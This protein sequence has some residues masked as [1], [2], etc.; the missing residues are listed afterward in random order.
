MV[1]T[2]EVAVT[3]VSGTGRLRTAETLLNRGVLMLCLF[4][5]Q[6]PALSQEVSGLLRFSDVL[7]MAESANPDLLTAVSGESVAE[8]HLRRARTIARPEL[9][10]TAE[11][12]RNSLEPSR[13]SEAEWISS[14]SQ[15]IETGG[16][17]RHRTRVAEAGLEVT[18]AGIKQAKRTLH[19]AVG[20]AFFTLMYR[21]AD[22]R[23]LGRLH[24][25]LE[26]TAALVAQSVDLGETAEN[27]HLLLELEKARLMDDILKL[28]QQRNNARIRLLALM[29]AEDI[30]QHITASD[31]LRAATLVDKQGA[32]IITDTGV[33]WS[34]S[35]LE[36]IAM[37]NHPDVLEAVHSLEQAQ[38]A[39]ALQRAMLIPNL[40]LNTGVRTFGGRV[41]L[42]AGIGLALPLWGGLDRGGLAITRS[43]EAQATAA[44][45][46]ARERVRAELATAVATVNHA[47]ER[48]RR[49][50]TEVLPLAY[51]LQV[52]NRT[53]YTLGE[54]TI[55]VLVY[56]QRTLL[57][58]IQLRN[59]AVLEYNL[60]QLSLAA[61]LGITPAFANL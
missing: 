37:R 3:L 26:S 8:A 31:S 40:L 39:V 7:Q 35:V 6:A 19:E 52:R 48:I 17:R 27:A 58:V 55:L 16:K 41:G 12:L 25:R 36:E 60:S 5:W 11:G 56:S 45:Q 30:R 24:D 15:E 4:A 57:E 13:G 21:E 59:E 54:S 43:V 49:I 53:A 10:F 14:L 28:E 23:T 22:H 50:S 18:R 42:D 2:D 44:L 20:T 34:F 47:A 46:A 29:G 32:A 33:A 51:A 38:A 1:Y 61:A 9:R